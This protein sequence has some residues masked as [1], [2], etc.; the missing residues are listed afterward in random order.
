MKNKRLL[1]G[2]Q[3]VFDHNLR[4]MR[5]ILRDRGLPAS[6]VDRMT[7]DTALRV[8]SHIIAREVREGCF[9]IV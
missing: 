5:Q 3:H 1:P 9:R 8:L 2:P 7:Y 6:D 4:A